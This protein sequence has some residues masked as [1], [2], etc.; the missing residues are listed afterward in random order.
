MR[1][2]F[3]ICSVLLSSACIE[4]SAQTD[5]SGLTLVNVQRFDINAATQQ[6]VDR[7]S[8]EQKAKSDAY[9]EGGYWILL[10][11]FVIDVITA[12]IFLSLGLSK[13][14][15][16]ITS[17]PKKTNVRNLLYIMMYIFL[18]FL[19]AFPYSAYT[20]YFR[21]HSYGLSN[22]TFSQ[23]LSE[24]MIKTALVLV[25]VSLLVMVIYLVMRKV[26]GKW[27][28]WGSGIVIIFLVLSIFIA[29]VFISPLFNK[30][31]PLETGKIRDEILSLARANSVPVTNVY[32]F[33]ASK[34]SSIISANVS[35]MGSTIRIS[36]NDNLLNKCTPAE[37]KSVMAHEL[38]HYVLNH[39][40]K[41]LINLSIF[42]IAVFALINLL[43]KKA[44]TRFGQKWGID[45]ISDIRSL[46][47]FAVLFSFFIFIA[48]PVTNNISR[49]AESEADIFGLNAAGEP[50]GFASVAMKLSDYRKIDPSRM[51][52]IIFYDHPSGKAR[53]LMAMKWKAEHLN[54]KAE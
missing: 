37:I 31:T 44:I 51:E 21:E 48:T 29:P 54:M 27:W 5:T 7:L 10:W 2:I 35:G 16:R 4:I 26:G 12:W 45:S 8:P 15:K 46:P 49:T 1:K 22:M 19:I 53:V 50:D 6:Y 52:E 42:I 9:Y 30:Y 24:G 36:L 43:M 47:L 18:A 39:P 33:N 13:W 41:L 28:I 17:R 34:Q 25:F 40:Y 23:W 32:Q 20:T 14:I 38:G 3:I 11:N